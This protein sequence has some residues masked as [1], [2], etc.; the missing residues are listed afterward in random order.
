MTTTIKVRIVRTWD[1]KPL[2]VLDGGPFNG[3]ELTPHQAH[4]LAAAISGTADAVEQENVASRHWRSRT[5]VIDDALGSKAP[6]RSVG[7]SS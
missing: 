5:V 4:Y 7:A 6:K 1:N 3:T 2:M